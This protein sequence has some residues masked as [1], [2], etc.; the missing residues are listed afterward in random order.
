M[1]IGGGALVAVLGVAA[2]LPKDAPTTEAVPIPTHTARAA[3]TSTAFAMTPSPLQWQGIVEQLDRTRGLAFMQAEPA[4]LLPVYA[5]NAA[6]AA[7]DQAMAQALKNAGAHAGS[8]PLRVRSVHE[9]YLTVGERVP[10]AMLTV[11]DVMGA[12]DIVDDQGVVLRHVPARSERRWHVELERS[13]L[14][15]WVYVSAV[16]AASQ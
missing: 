1:L 11:V 10:R 6:A 9:E 14:W 13:P 16:S 3:D 8:F 7:T 2:L 4:A 12:Y 5:T 15:G